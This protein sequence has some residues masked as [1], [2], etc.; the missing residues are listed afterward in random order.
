MVNLAFDPVVFARAIEGFGKAVTL[1]PVTK[2]VS[3]MG[4]EKLTDDTP[5]VIEAAFFTNKD[6]YVQDKPAL[7]LNADAIVICYPAQN[8]DKNYKVAYDGQT[9][10][11]YDDIFTRKL[12][13]VEMYKV[14]RLK[15]IDKS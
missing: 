2:V 11:V 10:R 13:E 6:Q 9:Y 15:I 7:I 12:G 8:I 14:A 3:N 4:G 1:T 5:V